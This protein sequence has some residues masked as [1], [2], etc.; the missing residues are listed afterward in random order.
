MSQTLLRNLLFIVGLTLSCGEA[1]DD[2]ADCTEN[3]YFD[4]GREICRACPAIV[5]PRCREGCS[6]SVVE[7][8]R[9][10]PLAQCSLDCD[11]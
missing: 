10:C 4:E 8:P 7:D 11:D 6:F 9:G 2:P 3:E 5:E 1:T